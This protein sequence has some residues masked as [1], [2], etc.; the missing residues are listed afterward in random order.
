MEE[1]VK[2]EVKEGG[3]EGEMK[4]GGVEGGRDGRRNEGME[5]EMEG[6]GGMCGGRKGRKKELYLVPSADRRVPE[7]GAFDHSAEY[8]PTQYH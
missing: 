4:E 7:P 5:G 8:T 6:G 1:Q 2:R 3:V